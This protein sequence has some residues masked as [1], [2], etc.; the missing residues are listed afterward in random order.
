MPIYF[1]FAAG[2]LTGFALAFVMLPL[3]R[4]GVGSLAK[5]GTRVAVTCAA[6]LLF[7]GVALGLYRV[8]GSPES[9]GSR[10]VQA[11]AHPATGA[12]SAQ[13]P[14]ESMEAAIARVEARVAGDKGSREDWLLLAQA[15]EY[16]GRSD[17]ARNA[18]ARSEGASANAIAQQPTSAAATSGAEAASA[19]APAANADSAE[20]ERRTRANPRDAD[21]WLALAGLY[22]RQ[23]EYAKARDAYGHLVQLKRMDAD[24][25]AD[26]ADV[27]A[28]LGNG[29]LRGEP[30]RS[31]ERALAL[32]PNHA[33]A[34]WLKAS[35]AH[36]ERRYADALAVWKQ[37]RA[38][39]PAESSDTAIVDENLRE[40]SQLAGTAQ[41]PAAQARPAPANAAVEISGSVSVD[42]SLAARVPPGATLF[43]Y[44]KAADAPGPPLA[45]IRQ[46]AGEWPVRFRLDDSLAM[47]PTRR[48]SQFD[49]VIV[50]ARISRSG[51]ATPAAGDLFVTSAVLKPA[52]RKKIEL[53]IAREVG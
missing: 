53:V 38:V 32:K 17:D 41:P 34:L 52:D 16:L 21:A 24:T 35:F 50:E 25:W 22:R 39:L 43:I 51:Q 15:Y 12:S 7:A 10:V 49:R 33:K 46:V 20:L 28:S 8:L 48:L 14:A 42:R 23:H 36:E 13:G 4:A 3:W 5:R 26:H 31:I 19:A 37:L 44:A 27:L 29:S 47:M 18:R 1:W 40:A 6:V 11:A 2:T 9:I 30:A 45:V